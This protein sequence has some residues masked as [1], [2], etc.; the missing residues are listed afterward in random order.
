M[1]FACLGPGEARRLRTVSAALLVGYVANKPTL[2]RASLQAACPATLPS[3]SESISFSVQCFIKF[4]IYRLL[5]SR[6]RF[7]RSG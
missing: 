4:L 1:V 2:A 5:A 6:A 7:P 3:I